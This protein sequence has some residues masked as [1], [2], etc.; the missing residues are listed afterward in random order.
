[1]KK[2]FKVLAV[3]RSIANIALVAVIGLGL[4]SCN[5]GGGTGGN[6][7]GTTGGGTGGGGSGNF[8]LVT[9]DEAWTYS[10]SVIFNVRDID[11]SSFDK[12]DWK[13]FAIT[14]DETS[15]DSFGLSGSIHDRTKNTANIVLSF[16]DREQNL[17]ITIG[18]SYAV[19][20]TYSGSVGPVKAILPFSETLTCINFDDRYK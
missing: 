4:A 16:I 19:T 18:K 5:T 2:T 14:V 1:M 9:R 20:V 10:G 12:I 7:G 3:M 6:T 15:C 8:K 17:V 13:D 11:S